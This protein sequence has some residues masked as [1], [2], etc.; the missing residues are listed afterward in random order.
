MSYRRCVRTACAI[1]ASLL[2]LSVAHAQ[3]VKNSEP[4][5]A[6]V[7]DPSTLR[8]VV[9]KRTA[10]AN[11]LIV[12][13]VHVD[14]ARTVENTLQ[15]YDDLISELRAALAVVNTVQNL[16]SDPVMRAVATELRPPVQA[17]IQ[18][19]NLRRDIYDALAAILP[20]SV[21]DEATRRYLN[22]E[23]EFYRR[24]AIDQPEA[25]RDRLRTL[26]A[27]L[28]AA[29]A[30][31][32][33]NIREGSRTFT[34]TAA[35]LEGVPRDFLARQQQNADGSIT[36]TSDN[37]DVRPV[38]EFAQNEAVKRQALVAGA[39]VAYPENAAS[40][41]KMIMVRSEIAKL[42][43]F[44][45][46]AAHEAASR[47]TRD[48]G[49]IAAFLEKVA[50]AS[51]AK[52]RTEYAQLL[53]RKRRDDPN[54]TAVGEWE[55]LYYTNLVRRELYDLDGQ[56]VRQY[57]PA[58]QVIAGVLDVNA[59]LYGVTFRSV[60][61]ELWH[62]SV[63]TFELFE[64]AR[65]I[66]RLYLDLHPRPGKVNS[67]ALHSGVRIGSARQTPESI[68]VAAVPGG[69]PGDPGLMSHE[70]VRT[71][72]HEFGHLM[73]SQ[74]AS[75]ARWIGINGLPQEADANEVPSMMAE[76]W[77]WDAKVLQT[78]ARHYKTGA[79][80]PAA[81]VAQ[82]RSASEFGKALEAR[83]QLAFSRVSLSYHDRDPG[84][85]DTSAMYRQ[86]T[87]ATLP[88][89]MH[90]DGHRELSIPHWSNPNYG[91]TY[92]TYLWSSVIAKDLFGQFDKKNLLA[93]A[94]ARRYREAVL[95]AGSSKPA[96]ELFEDFLGR[97]FTMTAW[98]RWLKEESPTTKKGSLEQ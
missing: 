81:L 26:R 15:V 44:P 24:R 58:E 79:P 3:P 23:L 76:E 51:E 32:D 92:Y 27:E 19:I 4:F 75:R 60:K 57:F 40:L 25:V 49:T 11:E 43:G 52:A 80:I 87:S 89:T 78:F 74:F 85:L 93:P 98:E 94:G 8:A 61:M 63:R 97:P 68:I 21:A 86:V 64:G 1:A 95:T 69:Q 28:Q 73:H 38:L 90:P 35:Q 84:S 18:A 48:H 17:L 72:F 71:L 66:G 62:P 39:T 47:M 91:A 96:Q 42:L 9:A 29:Q 13:L 5:N 70:E 45:N 16:H 37:V 6:G 10:T 2:S 30:E 59:R 50:L 65:M 82:M 67:G 41:R 53:R 31:Y 77:I 20:E 7:V 46:W 55:Y 34:T 14:G 33:R 22:R 12:R 88:L 54:A 36:L 83:R 56:Q